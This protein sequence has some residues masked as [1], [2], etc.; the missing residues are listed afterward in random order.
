MGGTYGES[1]SILYQSLIKIKAMPKKKL[2]PLALLQKKISVMANHK[3]ATKTQDSMNLTAMLTLAS[4]SGLPIKVNTSEWKYVLTDNSDNVLL[5]KR[6]N[7]EWYFSD[8]TNDLMDDILD[9]F[10]SNF[11]PIA[12]AT[13]DDIYEI[14]A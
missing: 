14:F 11:N 2:S 8:D 1:L 3:I 9:T 5:G 6:Q 13:S 12:N 10:G 4:F 7:D